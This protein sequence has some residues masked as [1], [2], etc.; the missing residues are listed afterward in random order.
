MK[1][2]IALK[3]LSPY[4]FA[5]LSVGLISSGYH[6]LPIYC[7]LAVVLYPVLVAMLAGANWGK[8]GHPPFGVSHYRAVAGTIRVY[9]SELMPA[10]VG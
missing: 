10:K 7:G 9:A 6:A 8:L 5:I 3:A 2:S 4:I 1:S